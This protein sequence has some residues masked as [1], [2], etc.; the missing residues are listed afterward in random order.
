MNQR[1]IEALSRLIGKLESWQHRTA[2]SKFLK[3]TSL[4]H[5]VNRAKH[6]LI[7]IEDKMKERQT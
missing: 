6:S 3:E 2:V 5:D 1:D 4:D 7:E